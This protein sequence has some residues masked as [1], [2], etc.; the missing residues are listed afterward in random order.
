MVR[1]DRNV[2]RELGLVYC[3]ED[4]QALTDGGDTDSLE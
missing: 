3:F 1:V 2:V 4:G